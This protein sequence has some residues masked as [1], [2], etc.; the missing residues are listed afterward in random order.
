MNDL[1]LYCSVKI[2]IEINFKIYVYVYHFTLSS[3]KWCSQYSPFK[4][5]S[6]QIYIKVWCVV[7]CCNIMGNTDFCQRTTI[8]EPEW[9]ES[10]WKYWPYLSR[11]Q[12][13]CKYII[14]FHN[15]M[16]LICC[17]LFPNS[18]EIKFFARKFDTKFIKKKIQFFLHQQQNNIK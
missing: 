3:T 5:F 8:R 10:H 18:T 17:I 9:R 11:Q 15:I 16:K 7:I 14:L 4:L 2:E 13:T 6:G 12:E 1:C